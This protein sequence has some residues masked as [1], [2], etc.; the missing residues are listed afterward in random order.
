MKISLY[1]EI[2]YNDLNSII[3]NFNFH[4]SF[5]RDQLHFVVVIFSCGK[6]VQLI[7]KA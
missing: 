2:L 3:F 1:W 4:A 7:P 6:S 5:A